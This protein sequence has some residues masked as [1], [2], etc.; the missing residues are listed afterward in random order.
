[1]NTGDD[2]VNVACLL[3][4]LHSKGIQVIPNLEVAG[5][6]DVLTDDLLAA[7]GRHKPDLLKLLVDDNSR[8]PA[9]G[10]G[11]L[12][13][14]WTERMA[15]CTITGE[16]TPAEAEA[17]AWAELETSLD[18]CARLVKQNDGS[19]FFELDPIANDQSPLNPSRRTSATTVA[20]RLD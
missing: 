17:V 10:I 15:I 18:P 20:S 4:S 2:V 14:A 3:D 11:D 19:F 6:E 16:L 7:I 9:I 13:D 8:A 12:R 5:S 1:M